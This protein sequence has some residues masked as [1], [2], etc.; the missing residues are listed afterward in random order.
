MSNKNSKSGKS[1]SAKSAKAKSVKV[2]VVKTAGRPRTKVSLPQGN[3]TFNELA[4][5]NGVMNDKEELLPKAERRMCLLTLRNFIAKDAA[6]GD[7][8]VLVVKSDKFAA[9]RGGTTGRKRFIYA[10]RKNASALKAAKESNVTVPIGDVPSVSEPVA[11][12]P[13]PEVSTPVSAETVA[14]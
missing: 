8:S 6:L 11:E 4:I 3:F 10:R 9:P 5:H 12:T 1:K 2:P 14:A 13:A 7:N